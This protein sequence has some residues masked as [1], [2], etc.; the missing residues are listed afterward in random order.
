[1]DRYVLERVQLYAQNKPKRYAAVSCAI[2]GLLVGVF[3]VFA[4][5]GRSGALPWPVAVLAVVIVGGLWGGVMSVFVVRLLRRMKPLPPDTDPARMHAA[6]RLVRKGALG[7]DPETNALAVQ[8]AE[9]VQ[10]V[11]RRKKSST[12]LFLCLTAL[13]VL[14]VAQEIRDGNVGAAVFYGA[15]ALLFLLGLTAGQAWADRRYRNAAKLRNS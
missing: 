4:P 15:V 10:S 2:G 13:S 14:L 1:M 6:R 11:P 8:L 9:Q 7:T 3:T 12:V 5:S